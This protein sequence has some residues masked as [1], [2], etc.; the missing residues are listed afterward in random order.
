MKLSHYCL[1]GLLGL[2]ALASCKT[3]LP[4]PYTGPPTGGY[5][6][7]ALPNTTALVTKYA[8]GESIPLTLGYYQGDNPT[9]ITVFQ[10]TKTDSAQVG[11]YPVNGTFNQTLAV[12]TQAVPYTVPTTYAIGT[13]VRVDVTLNFADG[14]QRLRRITY[15]VASSPT[16]TNGTPT[17]TYRNGLGASAQTNGDVLG[18]AITLN[19]GGIS[20]VPTGATTPPSNLFKNVDSL[21]YYARTGTTGALQRQGVIKTP[22]AGVVNS[23]TIDVRIPSG[24]AAAGGAQFVFTAFAQTTSTTLTSALVP[25][26]AAGTPLATTRRGTVSFGGGSS[27]DSLAFNLSAGLPEPAANASTGKDLQVSGLSTAGSGALTL[28]APNTTRYYKL[29]SSQL[30]ANPYATATANQVG[31]LLYQNTASADLGTPAAG[32]VYAVRLRGAST[33]ALLRILGTRASTSGGVGR[34]KFEY[35]TL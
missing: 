27:A 18:Y 21:V 22:T 15:T 23:R 3:N 28:S 9:T 29:S 14:G 12:N 4:T 5:A 7:L 11:S 1:L 19:A 13:A 30:A 34:V 35:R 26:A 31:L 6:N 16:L 2:G 32:D 20:T 24:S 25:V 17:L 33:Y 10:A 8:P